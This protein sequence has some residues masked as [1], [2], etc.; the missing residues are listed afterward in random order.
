MLLF[1][2]FFQLLVI[3]LFS[4]SCISFQYYFFQFHVCFSGL[5]QLLLLLLSTLYS[6]HLIVQFQLN[7]ERFSFLLFFVSSFFLF[8]SLFR[9]LLSRYPLS[10]FAFFRRQTIIIVISC[11]SYAQCGR[12]KAVPPFVIQLYIEL[13]GYHD[14]RPTLYLINTLRAKI[15]KLI[16]QAYACFQLESNSHLIFYCY[17]SG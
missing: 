17:I 2:I 6:L 5:S 4:L 10:L 12:K 15:L 14:W 3:I 9:I 1:F 16:I 11:F 13:E 8:F 7:L